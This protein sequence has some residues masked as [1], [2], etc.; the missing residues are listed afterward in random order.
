[1]RLSEPHALISAHSVHNALCSAQL[2]VPICSWNPAPAPGLLL[3]WFPVASTPYQLLELT[4]AV[5]QQE[6][7]SREKAAP[8]LT[9]ATW[10][11]RVFLKE[12]TWHF[13]R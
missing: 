8:S 10:S 12:R 2:W 9:M 1:M 3:P 6:M 5:S 7:D 13:L 11:E 4:R